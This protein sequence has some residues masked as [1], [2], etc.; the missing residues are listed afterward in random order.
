MPFP[1]EKPVQ[2]NIRRQPADEWMDQPGISYPDHQLALKGLARLNWA[3]GVHQKVWRELLLGMAAKPQIGPVR[4]LDLA[5]GGA[6]LPIHLFKQ[7]RRAG[8]D[9]RILAVDRAEGALRHAME[10]CM[11]SGVPCAMGD[12]Y[13]L[14]PGIRFRVADALAAPLSL[15]QPDW[16]TSS[17]FL[18][19]LTNREAYDLLVEL[20]GLVQGGLVIADLSRGWLNQMLVTIGSHLLSRS[21][22]V[23]NDGPASI[24][25]A[26]TIREA[27]GLAE[28][29]GLHGVLL[30]SSFPGM[31]L[32]RWEKP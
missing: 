19:H 27:R 1:P 3:S 23:H 12:D 15:P 11:A 2:P 28:S 31:W 22:L 25:A 20:T 14:E 13:P 9:L 5:T 30:R 32:M 6:D 21:P 29:A 26:F 16:V 10:R 8:L 18:H 17:L 4:L 24:R 7:S